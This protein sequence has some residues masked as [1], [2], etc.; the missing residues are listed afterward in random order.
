MVAMPEAAMHH[1]EGQAQSLGQSNPVVAQS[2][3]GQGTPARMSG[4]H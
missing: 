4:P 3:G 2:S 1:I